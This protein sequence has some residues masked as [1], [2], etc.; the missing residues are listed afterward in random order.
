MNVFEL[1]T[2]L[3]R[4]YE[5]FARSFTTIRADD[6]QDQIN[7]IYDSGQFW[8]KP[9]IG[10]NPEFEP[11]RSVGEIVSQGVIDPAMADVFAL[12]QVRQS[13]ILHRHQDEALMKALQNKNFIVTTGTGSGKSLCFFVPIIDRI[14]KARRAG[15]PRK[16][17]AIIIYPMNALANSQLEELTK[18]ALSRLAS[19]A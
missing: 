4:R 9:L 13:I 2:D 6:L 17:R 7:G 12:G 10:L 14:L 11:G 19:A 1:D 18:S 3:I 15:E 8:P 16:T 5:E